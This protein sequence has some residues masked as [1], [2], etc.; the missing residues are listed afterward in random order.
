[1][2]VAHWQ[3]ANRWLLRADLECDSVIKIPGGIDCLQCRVCE[4]LRRDASFLRSRQ[5]CT[6]D[7]TPLPLDRAEAR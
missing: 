2:G 3:C 1:M 5:L 6:R 7:V 4:L